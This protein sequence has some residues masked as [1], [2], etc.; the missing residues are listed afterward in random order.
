[1]AAIQRIQIRIYGGSHPFTDPVKPDPDLKLFL[2]EAANGQT[3]KR[4]GG[5]GR[6]IKEKLLSFED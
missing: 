4:E 1:M 5:K 6:A 3:I 2:R